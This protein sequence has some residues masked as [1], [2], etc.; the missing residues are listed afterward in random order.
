MKFPLKVACLLLSLML[1]LNGAGFAAMLDCERD[2]C[3]SSPRP[4]S[5]EGTHMSCHEDEEISQALDVN[6]QLHNEPLP[7]SPL[8]FIQC[9]TDGQTAWLLTQKAEVG[10]ELIASSVL[11]Q[12]LSA[13]SNLTKSAAPQF[14][15]PSSHQVSAPLRN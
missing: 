8:N 14:S 13:H 2:C 11:E 4:V 3:Q 1:F 10:H 15:P 12:V 9:G 5:T 7:T 6:L